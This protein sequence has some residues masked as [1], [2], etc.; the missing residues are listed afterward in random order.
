MPVDPTTGV[1]T[2][3]AGTEVAPGET[4]ESTWANTLTADIEQGLN[5]RL[6]DNSSTFIDPVLFADGTVSNPGIAWANTPTTGL[7][8]APSGE[9]RFA[10]GGVDVLQAGPSGMQVWDNTNSFWYNVLDERQIKAT[11]RTDTTFLHTPA[12]PVTD[13]TTVIEGS[14]TTTGPINGTL[15]ATV[16]SNDE[17]PFITGYETSAASGTGGGFKFAANKFN[18]GV[19]LRF[20]D[21]AGVQGDLAWL[22]TPGSSMS[23]YHGGSLKL[24]TA[25]NG[26]NVTG[27]LDAD[28]IT[29]SGTITANSN[30]TAYASDARLKTVVGDLNTEEAL[31]NVCSWSKVRY[32]WNEKAAE[33][34]GFDTVPV[35][36][37]LFAGEVHDQ[38]P[39]LA[40]IA[41]FDRSETPEID[42]LSLSGECY[43]TLDYG[44][45]VAVQA[46]AITQLKKELDDLKAMTQAKRR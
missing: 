22:A 29:T 17:D 38:Y 30:I 37:G 3:P 8:R 43:R 46:A 39:E 12:D 1:Y 44:R 45:V 23:L 10:T 32:Q 20:V 41:P 5:S 9:Q 42:G 25:S 2:L 19:S 18:G 21:T 13:S 24:T 31:A 34:A 4:I 11:N 7:Y 27:T 15:S 36:I 33:L 14:L 6:W 28:T 16:T 35:E 26:I 40:P